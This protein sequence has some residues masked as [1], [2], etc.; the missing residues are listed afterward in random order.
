MAC[1]LLKGL[2]NPS[3]LVSSLAS[4]TELDALRNRLSLGHQTQDNDHKILCAMLGITLVVHYSPTV[5]ENV[6]DAGPESPTMH[7]KISK[8][9][10]GEGVLQG[11]FELMV[12]ARSLTSEQIS[13]APVATENDP[14]V[15]KHCI[16]LRGK[17]L[18]AAILSGHK[19][20]E[21][22][23]MCL[24][25]Q[26][27]ALH[28]GQQDLPANYRKHLMKTMPA[29]QDSCKEFEKGCIVG[30]IYI[31]ASVAMTQYRAKVG[32]TSKCIFSEQDWK[33]LPEHAPGCTCDPHAHGPFLNV[34]QHY[35]KFHQGIP[36]RGKL[37]KWPLCPEAAQKIH[38][39][40][41]EGSYTKRSN[42]P[43]DLERFQV[44]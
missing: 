21:N 22:R 14:S 41:A 43:N 30:M 2:E 29:M 26:W 24:E 12:E 15:V 8:R 16:T 4:K 17:E 31:S 20:V 3:E 40:L 25:K 5:E 34:I 18:A 33:V 32:C 9:Q 37:G 10:D 36:A 19:Q 6:W 38:R 23:T 7:V 44:G 27:I 42:D 28:V 1:K 13:H 35:I 39:V 11:H